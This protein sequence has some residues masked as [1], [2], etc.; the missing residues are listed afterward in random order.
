MSLWDIP[1]EQ[2]IAELKKY[3]SKVTL[4]DLILELERRKAKGL[5]TKKLEDY[6]ET[7]K[8]QNNEKANS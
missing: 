2:V 1:I 5:P 8:R 4:E 3:E 6:I 7:Y